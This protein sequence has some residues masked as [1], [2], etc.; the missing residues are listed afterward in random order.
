MEQPALEIDGEARNPHLFL[1]F[2][3]AVSVKVRNLCQ[4]HNM[5]RIIWANVSFH[6]KKRATLCGQSP[7]TIDRSPLLVTNL[8]YSL[9]LVEI[10]FIEPIISSS[11]LQ[12]QSKVL[13]HFLPGKAH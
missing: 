11:A 12:F 5:L 1:R 2:V 9:C 10:Q 4:A 7:I 6:K 8:L 13:K 3:A